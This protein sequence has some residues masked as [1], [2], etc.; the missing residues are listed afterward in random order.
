MMFDENLIIPNKCL[1]VSEGAIIPFNSK[2]GKFSSNI[3]SFPKPLHL[4]HAP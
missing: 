2:G 4:L 1:S 3:I